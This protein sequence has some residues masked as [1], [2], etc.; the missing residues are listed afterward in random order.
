MNIK[1]ILA[2]TASVGFLAACNGGGGSDP[3]P[4]AVTTAEGLWSGTTSTS[5]SLTGI[6]LGNGTYWMLYSAPNNSTVIAGVLV[7]RGSSLNSSFS[8]SEGKDFNFEGQGIHDATISAS[9][10]PRDYFNGSISYP[11]LNQTNTFTTTF[12]KAF[13]NPLSLSAIAGSYSGNAVVVGRAPE[14]TT[15]GVTSEGAVTGSSSNGCQFTGNATPFANGGIYDLSITF[16]G[17]ACA[18]G[19]NT[20]TGIVYYDVGTKKLFS[21]ALNYTLSNGFVFFGDKL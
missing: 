6:V 20:V 17:G 1:K 21:I 19:T 11:S 12:N 18:N 8:T 14:A 10:V 4:V 5:R 13:D 3:G 16:G 7:G 2:V 15:F 9:Y